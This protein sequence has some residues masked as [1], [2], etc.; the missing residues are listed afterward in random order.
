MLLILLACSSSRIFAL[1][2]FSSGLRFF[3]PI[4]KTSDVVLLFY[5]TSKVYIKL[6]IV[7]LVNIPPYTSVAQFS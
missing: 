2:S 4:V 3:L 5:T 6:G 1:R 7:P